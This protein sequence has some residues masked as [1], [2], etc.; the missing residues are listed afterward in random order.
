MSCWTVHCSARHL[1]PHP[2]L[3]LLLR[4]LRLLLSALRL[5]CRP[6]LLLLQLPLLRQQETG[7][8]LHDKDLSWSSA[9]PFGVCKRL[10]TLPKENE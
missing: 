10:Q 6:L 5:Q 2:L 7:C 9:E 8:V 4:A 3:G 1:C